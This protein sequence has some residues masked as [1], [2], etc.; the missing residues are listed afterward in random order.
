MGR[1]RTTALSGFFYRRVA[2]T[3]AGVEAELIG[4]AFTAR[5][6]PFDGPG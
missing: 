3:F 4:S 2:A 5:G 1:A 6:I